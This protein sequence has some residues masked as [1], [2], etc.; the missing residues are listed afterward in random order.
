[1]RV[2]MPESLSLSIPN[3]LIKPCGAVVPISLAET[4]LAVVHVPAWA[5]EKLVKIGNKKR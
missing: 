2:V 5:A 1:M 4:V 3:E